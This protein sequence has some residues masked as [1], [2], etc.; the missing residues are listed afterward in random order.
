MKNT[1][2][3]SNC[4]KSRSIAIPN[5]EQLTLVL[6]NSSLVDCIQGFEEKTQTNVRQITFKQR[7]SFGFG[8]S[9]LGLREDSR[10]GQIRGWSE[11]QT[12]FAP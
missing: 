5:S 8:S 1:H 12:G 4:F 2:D 9:Q 7:S 3:H 10:R 6:S 11:V